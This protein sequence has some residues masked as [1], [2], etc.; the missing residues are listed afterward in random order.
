MT[1][2]RTLR[3]PR[4]SNADYRWT[5]PKMLAFL[6]ALAATGSVAEAARS[7]GMSRQSAHRLRARA[8]EHFGSVWDGAMALAYRARAGAR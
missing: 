7:V 6:R 5:T 2:P 4:R 3:P 8:G 1:R